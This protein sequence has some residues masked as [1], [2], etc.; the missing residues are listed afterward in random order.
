M[1]FG[2]KVT[3]KRPE[4]GDFVRCHFVP[5]CDNILILCIFHLLQL[6]MTMTITIT[7]HAYLPKWIL[8]LIH[9]S[10]RDRVRIPIVIVIVIESH[11]VPLFFFKSGT[12]IL[13]FFCIT[14]IGAQEYHTTI[15]HTSQHTMP[16]LC[17]HS[18]FALG[19]LCLRSGFALTV[20]HKTTLQRLHREGS[21]CS[22]LNR[23]DTI[24]T[25]F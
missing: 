7:L 10:E 24:K 17:L 5:I 12:L 20:E 25:G 11:F 14:I 9:P 22:Q 19:S 8:N 2:W 1:K 6:L 4:N 16:S 15:S 21:Q 18:A 3:R 13:A 23:R